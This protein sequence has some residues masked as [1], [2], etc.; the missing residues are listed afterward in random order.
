MVVSAGRTKRDLAQRAKQ[1]LEAGGGRLLGAV[2]TNAR[3]EKKLRDYYA[4]T[5]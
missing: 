1:Q 5:R 3:L 4:G 2:L